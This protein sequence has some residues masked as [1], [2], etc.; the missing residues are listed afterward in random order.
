VN[1]FLHIRQVRLVGR[2]TDIRRPHLQPAPATSAEVWFSN[3]F[4]ISFFK[5]AAVLFEMSH[6]GV[7]RK[8]LSLFCTSNQRF[9][10]IGIQLTAHYS[11]KLLFV[12]T[13]YLLDCYPE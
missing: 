12:K 9:E 1:V 7:L 11:E 10:T 13:E 4:R 5:R 3:L 8:R 6:I 2:L